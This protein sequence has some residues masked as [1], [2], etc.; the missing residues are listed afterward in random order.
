MITQGLD[1]Y[2]NERTKIYVRCSPAV[3]EIFDKALS[4]MM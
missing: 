2:I 3:N 1:E 4:T